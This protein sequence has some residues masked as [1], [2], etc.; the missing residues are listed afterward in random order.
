MVASRYTEEQTIE[1][2]STI[3]LSEDLLIRSIYRLV[4]KL[5]IL[6]AANTER[7]RN[8]T[9]SLND[10]N[11]ARVNRIDGANASLRTDLSQSIMFGVADPVIANYEFVNI[12]TVDDNS[13]PI[14]DISAGRDN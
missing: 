3:G 7:A 9:N 1:R 10:I 8:I 11:I 14:V 6:N 4:P 12:D 5:D 13:N 2:A